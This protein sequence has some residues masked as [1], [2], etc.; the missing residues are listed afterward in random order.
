MG[1]PLNTI[2]VKTPTAT[3]VAKAE[4]TLLKAKQAE[5]L[6]KVLDSTNFTV[7]TTLNAREVRIEIE[8][9]R[10]IV[11]RYRVVA[12]TKENRDE[13]KKDLARKVQAYAKN[14]D[15]FVNGDPSGKKFTKFVGGAAKALHKAG[16]TFEQIEAEYLFVVGLLRKK[17]A[18]LEW[19]EQQAIDSLG[20]KKSVKA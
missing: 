19:M 6:N 15:K 9:L 1:T 17:E 4:E 16:W 2:L 18:Q 14:P 7:S 11:S 20:K 3:A 5:Q 8:A 13:F 10:T 12:D